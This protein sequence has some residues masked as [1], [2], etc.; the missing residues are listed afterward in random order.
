MVWVGLAVGS[1][2]GA[3]F[4][5]FFSGRSV[6]YETARSASAVEVAKLAISERFT[7]SEIDDGSDVYDKL[8][9]PAMLDERVGEGRPAS[10]KPAGTGSAGAGNGQAAPR[11]PGAQVAEEIRSGANAAQAQRSNEAL[12]AD[13]ETKNAGTKIDNGPKAAEVDALFEDSSA[14]IESSDSLM[15]AVQDADLSAR[16]KVRVLGGGDSQSD[17]QEKVDRPDNVGQLL[18]ERLAMARA[19]QEKALPFAEPGKAVVKVAPLKGEPAAVDLKSADAKAAVSASTATKLDKPVKAEEPSKASENQNLVR[20]VL[21]QGFFAQVAAPTKLNEAEDIAKRLK[22]S[23][24]PV[25]IETANVRGENYY[26]VLVGP[27]QDK[28]TADRL[29]G[30]LQRERYLS[31]APFIRR[32]K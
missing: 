1:I 31:G 15:A 10:N 11:S 23:G 25:V 26:R 3:Y 12:K 7:E 30:Q 5:G 20:Q 21:P 24:F 16:Q 18:E 27:E 9:R 17:G 14:P 13:A 28:V 8:S 22:R 29:V 2:A 4:I 6:G 19:N 32:V